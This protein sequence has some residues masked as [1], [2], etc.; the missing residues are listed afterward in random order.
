MKNE[1]QYSP[2]QLDH[3]VVFL[4]RDWAHMIVD[5]EVLGL[6]L[7]PQDV[8]KFCLL[9]KGPRKW[10]VVIR[11]EEGAGYLYVDMRQ[12]ELC[13]D[14]DDPVISVGVLE[15][16]LADSEDAWIGVNLHVDKV[17]SFGFILNQ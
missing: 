13:C 14:V 5:D 9:G 7:T 4:T 3:L 10:E 8:F 6:R 16:A 2:S 15:L 11:C 17:A 12:S 1:I